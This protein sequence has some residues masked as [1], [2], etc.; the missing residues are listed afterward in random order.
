MNKLY[1]HALPLLLAAP[2]FTLA[3]SLPAQGT[4][5]PGY[6]TKESSGSQAYAYYIGGYKTSRHQ[7]AYGDLK[8]KG[9]KSMKEIS[10]RQD[11]S[12][13]SSSAVARSWTNLTVYVADTNLAAMSNTWT[14]NHLSTPTM[15]YNAKHTWPAMTSQPPG[16]P[17]PWDNGGL[18]IPF[19]TTY[20]YT[21]KNDIVFD[22]TFRGG[23]LSNAATW[24]TSSRKSAYLDGRSITTST[25]GSLYVYGL[26]GKCTFDTGNTSTS[27]LGG[28]YGYFVAYSENMP[29]NRFRYWTYRTNMPKSTT[30]LHGLS[31]GGFSSTTKPGP[32][33]GLGCQAV[34]IDF[35]K[36]FLVQA[37]KT[38]SSGY[39]NQ[40][41]Q[42]TPFIASAVGLNI[43]AQG[44]WNDTVT[45]AVKLTRTSR[46][47]VPALPPAPDFSGK[48]LYRYG[49]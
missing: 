5:P 4:L 32:N 15:V 48:R 13:S 16:T 19:T 37:F 28:G 7:T 26:N 17:N 27:S 22:Y 44:I 21:A 40:P 20:M 24:G 41:A 30:F 18:K 1:P 14:K 23:T 10:F 35:T 33:P 46:C 36:L 3:T 42:Y 8:G 6:L 25:Q 38:T 12:S 29:S 2:L 47:N 11:G 34:Q 9:T 49:N 45:K 39:F 43:W 31:L